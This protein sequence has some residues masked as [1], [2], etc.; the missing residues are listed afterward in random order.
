[1]LCDS[2]LDAGCLSR[3]QLVVLVSASSG[4]PNEELEHI[5]PFDLRALRRY[6]DALVAGWITEDPSM[7][8]EQ[9]LEQAREEVS[10]HLDQRLAAFMPG[11]SLRELTFRTQLHNEALVVCLVPVWVLALRHDPKEPPLRFLVNG[12]TGK[13]YGRVPVSWVKVLLAVL[14]GLLVIGGLYLLLKS[15]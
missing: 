7:T 13:V 11:D 6:H 8:Q 3:L 5:E 15:S 10:S 9:C 4:L 12:Q 14:V 2:L 1:M